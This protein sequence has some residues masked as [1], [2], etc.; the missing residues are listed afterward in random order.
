MDFGFL[1]YFVMV[2]YILAIVGIGMFFMRR[3][4]NTTDY[5][6]GGRFFHWVP[7]AI[8]IYV[9]LFS[10]I[11]FI[12]SPG[13]AYNNGMM[14]FLFSVFAVPGAIL[15]VILFVPFFRRLSLTTAYEYLEL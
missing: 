6:L 13:E 8:S 15:A 11:S 4:E 7:I 12:S 2:I 10:A 14:L 3:H 9:S 1:D 5:F